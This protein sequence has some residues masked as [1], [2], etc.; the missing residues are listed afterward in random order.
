[1]ILTSVR[2]ARALIS[3]G[4]IV[5][6]LPA[7]AQPLNLEFL[8]PELG[9][10]NICAAPPEPAAP[11][12]L[13]V[14][15]GEDTLTDVQR[16][17]FL[18]SEIRT[19]MRRD[20][21]RFFDFI[22]ALIARR[23]AIDPDYSEI[24]ATLERVTLHLRADRL[25]SL[26]ARALLPR[27]RALSGDMTNNQRLEL[28]QYYRNGV[29]VPKD[30]ADAQDLT[31][32]AAYGGNA[33]ALM[34]IAR[35]QIA[36]ELIE[37]WDAPLDLTVTLAFGGILGELNPGVC[38][39]AETIAQEYVRGEVVQRN[40]AIALAW[41]KFAADLGGAEA[42]WSVVEIHLNAEGDR[43]NNAE[44]RRY[45]KRAVELGL[46]LDSRQ[47][48]R[49]VSSGALTPDELEALLGFNVSEDGR[50]N[51]RSII[52]KLSLAINVDGLEPDKEGIYMQFLREL[53]RMPEAPGLVFTR[54]AREV[55]VQNGRWSG[56]AE[57]ISLLEEAVRRDDEDGMQLLSEILL[58]Y[59]DDPLQVNKAEN[60]LLDSVDRFGLVSSLSRLDALYRCQRNDAPRLSEARHWA[61]AYAATGHTT[62][63]LS[64]TDLLALD[65]HRSPETIAMIQ[66][67]ALRGRTSA[68]AGQAQRVQANPI[69]PNPALE[70][71]ASRMNR[72][73]QA[74][75]A[76]AEFEFDLAVTPRQRDQAIE[77]FRR[78]YLNNGVTT[79]LDLAVA[80]VEQDG[81]NPELVEEILHLLTMAGNR[82]EG[83]AIRLKSR[84]LADDLTADAYARSARA[85]YAE[86]AE[87]IEARGD[88][89]ALV[90][91]LPFVPEDR[92]DDYVDRAVSVM[93]CSI[94]D[95]TELGDAYALRGDMPMA[96][97]WRQVGLMMDGGH[98]LSK[99][100]L[101]D[102]QMAQFNTGKAPSALDMETQA[103][104]DGD[105]TARRRLYVLTANP[106][107]PS[108]DPPAAA[109]HL[110]S[111]LTDKTADAQ[112]VV[113]VMRQYRRSDAPVREAVETRLDMR[114]VFASVAEAGDTFAQF[115]L[116]MLLRDNALTAEELQQSSDW[117]RKAALSGH[118]GAMVELARALGLGL[119]VP[120]NKTEALRWLQRARAAGNTGTASLATL[121]R[122]SS[123]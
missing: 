5:A 108:Y 104:A 14:D 107:L 66:T 22:D 90:S 93:N 62:I 67:Q 56:E 102:P 114:P 80:L 19:Y 35:A 115:E 38:R 4:L 27:L 84:L 16:I 95:A 97:H 59:R 23:T 77:F 7:L 53:A 94:K 112:Q 24:D 15:E 98:V 83:A 69:V 39:R 76:F 60:L 26:Q 110:A 8:P 36:G 13:A 31:R 72:S 65:P 52:P 6:A 42:A 117:L 55:M 113:W 44:M 105:F 118:D 71:W 45:L 87:A 88:F 12:D 58:R 9:E 57:A 49:L 81:R 37:G 103:L 73:D 63:P 46:N 54:L 11:D 17:R 61:E 106:D 43:K 33:R 51:R 32:E 86:F 85:V 78:V 10:R 109:G 34:E 79:A 1:M 28:A 120:K 121:I 101:S 123:D 68:L 40:P 99:L 74:L 25:R 20:A 116:G 82:G 3:A 29:G 96:Y 92:I 91:A 48:G 75:E 47:S 70:F 119:G 111:I 122:A 89:L 100:R 18:N 21:D 41:L 30:V 50:R 64:S 2:I